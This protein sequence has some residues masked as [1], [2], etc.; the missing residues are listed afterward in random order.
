[1][2]A[3]R[4]AFRGVNWLANR[5]RL[6]LLESIY[7]AI[8]KSQAVIEMDM[9]G[10]VLAANDGYLKMFGYTLAE[11]R[12]QPYAL[13]VDPADR[14]SAE[15]RALW[16]HMHAGQYEQGRFRR[17]GKNSREV[18]VRASFNPLIGQNGKPWRVL[19]FASEI[20]PIILEARAFDSAVHES[21]EVIQ[22]ALGGA[23]DRRI[24]MSGKTG[25]L[26]LLTGSINQLIAGVST[27]V[28][29][30]MQV[31]Q[32]A[33]EGDL[34]SRVRADD[35]SGHFKAL[36]DSVNSMIQSMMEIVDRLTTTA[37]EVKQG[38]EEISRG[39]F[40]LSR[41]T[42]EQASSLEQT[43]A[44]LE[45][46]TSAVKN[47]ADNAAQASQLAKA[48]REQA[49]RGGHV[50][51][52]AVAAMSEINAASK[53][54]ADIIGVIDE[55]AFQTNLLALNAAVEAARAGQEGR[56]FAVVASEVRNL[57]SRS[58]GAA[59]EIKALIHDSVGKVNEGTRLVDESGRVLDEIL[60][61][62][63][64]VT[65]VMA[66][67]AHSSREQ[68]SGIEQVNKAVTSMD[69]MT[70]QNAAL[71]EESTAAAQALTEQAIGL[72]KLIA[73]FRRSE[74]TPSNRGGD[75]REN[76]VAE[77]HMGR[78]RALG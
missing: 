27:T 38:A 54:I 63:K 70:Q 52:S 68:A 22:A 5:A 37:Q 28:A 17:M 11:I 34:T 67:I 25:N 57:A 19:K 64:K 49:E 21:Q 36:A 42:E 30:T 6:R 41:R 44:S 7:T 14:E 26:E 72:T 59:K 31:V 66:E 12:G 10:T 24:S 47:N 23:G 53:K 40:E 77:P 73:H 51:G 60:T 48:A 33:V 76:G 3:I 15:Y 74:S 55:I 18:W 71:A 50:V 20:T 16:A 8:N 46:M 13:F 45:Q 35:K 2:T 65:D 1:M 75:I 39:N 9:D 61:R 62:V 56:G 43:A 29:E 69:T 58:A 78:R 32:R 4:T